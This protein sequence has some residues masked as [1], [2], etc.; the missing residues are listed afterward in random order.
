M[1]SVSSA[2]LLPLRPADSLASENYPG[3]AAAAARVKTLL[4]LWTPTPQAMFTD[5]VSACVGE[6]ELGRQLCS[7]FRKLDFP[8]YTNSVLSCEGADWALLLVA[9]RSALSCD[10]ESRQNQ[11]RNV[12]RPAPALPPKLLFTPRSRLISVR[13]VET[14][15]WL[16]EVGQWV[17]RES[18]K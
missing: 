2:T 13:V 11:V 17:Q 12:R 9:L 10:W 8:G 14:P 5:R 15:L 1:C 4:D 6:S 18:E 16:L 7:L 3:K